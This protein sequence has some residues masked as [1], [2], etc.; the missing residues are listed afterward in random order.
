MKTGYIYWRISTW[1]KLGVLMVGIMTLFGCL[2][3]LDE[4]ADGQSGS[5]LVL[6]NLT[7]TYIGQNTGDVDIVANLCFTGEEYVPEDFQDHMVDV[8]IRNDDLPNWEDGVPSASDV[9]ITAYEVEYTLIEDDIED[10]PNLDTEIFYSSWT[11]PANSSTTFTAHMV[12]IYKKVEYVTKFGVDL[13]EIGQYEVYYVASFTF[14]GQDAFGHRVSIGG[15][16]VILLADFN[17]CD[18]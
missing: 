13:E 12:P 4:D 5:F 9:T 17:Y 10:A 11:I 8:T 7:P 15:N 1:L 6:D 18:E 3:S 16:A 14:E 2:G